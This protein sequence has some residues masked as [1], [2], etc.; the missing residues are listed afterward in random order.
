MKVLLGLLMSLVMVQSACAIGDTEKG[1]LIGAGSLIILQKIFQ[2][3]RPS[4]SQ[5]QS[6]PRPGPGY[7]GYQG[8]RYD[9]QHRH[10]QECV[11]RRYL[12]YD[13]YGRPYEVRERNCR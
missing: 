10:R 4:Y 13:R 9:N 7:Q 3:P 5:P 8:Q 2:D 12:E 6:Q 11:E 1:A